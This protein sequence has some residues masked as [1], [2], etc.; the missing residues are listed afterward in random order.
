MSEGGPPY[1]I[2]LAFMQ[3]CAAM[4]IRQAFTSSA[5]PRATPTERLARCVY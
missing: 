5:I 4:G 3:A 1:L 2:P